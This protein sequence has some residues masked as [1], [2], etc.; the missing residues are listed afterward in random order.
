M[1][2]RRD[3]IKKLAAGT[4][5]AMAVPSILASDAFAPKADDLKGAK[6]EF[7]VK[8]RGLP[9]TGTFLDEISTDIPHQNWGVREWDA[10]FRHM[11]NMG[12]DTVIIIRCGLRKFMTYPSPYLL[13]KGYYMPS[14]DLVDLFCQLADKYKMALYIG[15]YDSDEY[16]YTGVYNNEIEVNK[17]IIDE[18]WERYGH[19]DSFKG[20]YLSFEISRASKGA[21]EG[22][23]KLGRQCKEISGNLPTFISP[24]IEGAKAVAA[25]S[26]ELRRKD[27]RSI[28][29]H[30]RDWNEIFD[31]IHPFVDAVAFQDGY[32]DYDEI[33]AFLSV[34]KKLADR[35]GMESWTNCESFD[36]D[37]PIKFLPIKFDKLRMKLEAAKRCGYNKA[38]TFEF[39]HFLS[40]QSAYLQAGNNYDRYCEYFNIK[41]KSHLG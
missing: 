2:N 5:A 39:S 37:M 23:Q 38:I 28:E 22:Y 8:E 21:I 7:L 19:Y 29:E 26:A 6:P 16:W 25:S 1:D 12:I 17:F 35:Y 24:I 13:K 41:N 3:F 14:I 18:L 15:L 40:P 31:G 9:V 27:P 36:R 34:N 32:T 11:K 4:A 33:D 20:W 10:D 30:E